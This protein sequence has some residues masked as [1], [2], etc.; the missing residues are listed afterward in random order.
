M[1]SKNI[2]LD[3]VELFNSKNQLIKEFKKELER[4]L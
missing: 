4:A 1:D 3:K 2:T